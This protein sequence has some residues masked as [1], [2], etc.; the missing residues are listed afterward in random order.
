M[1]TH[2][3]ALY[4]YMIKLNFEDKDLMNNLIAALYNKGKQDGIALGKVL[5]QIVIDANPK[6][7]Q[8]DI[9]LVIKC[10]NI[11]YKGQ[12]N[13]KQHLWKSRVLGNHKQIIAPI[14]IQPI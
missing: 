12:F 5:S 11:F 3:V 2:A 4:Y 1:D 7:P 8:N 14:E 6:S 9:D 10:L 13:F